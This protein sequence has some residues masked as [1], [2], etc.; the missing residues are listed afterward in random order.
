MIL[1]FQYFRVFFFWGLFFGLC[2]NFT[3]VVLYLLPRGLLGCMFEVVLELLLS[4]LV[5]QVLLLKKL[6]ELTPVFL[7]AL[8]I[9]RNH[10]FHLLKQKK[11]LLILYFALVKKLV[12]LL[13]RKL[14]RSDLI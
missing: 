8:E 5:H 3:Q 12:G 13:E 10:G 7:L 14:R 11:K 1:L 9:I 6:I 2:L 4:H